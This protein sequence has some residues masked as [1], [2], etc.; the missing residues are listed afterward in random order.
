M[1]NGNK[2]RYCTEVVDKSMIIGDREVYVD[3]KFTYDN[4]SDG[5]LHS[6]F[7]M[8]YGGGARDVLID[9]YDDIAQ[10]TE[11][12]LAIEQLVGHKVKLVPEFY[13][14]WWSKWVTDETGVCF[15]E[16]V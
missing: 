15:A 12:L 11:M 13:E 10:S 1:F 9:A 5:A 4:D 7:L 8:F 16:V 6:V 2:Q 3:S 14:T